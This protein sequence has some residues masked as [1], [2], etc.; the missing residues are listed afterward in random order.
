MKDSTPPCETL[1]ITRPIANREDQIALIKSRGPN[2]RGV[3][4]AYLAKTMCLN[5]IEPQSTSLCK[6]Q[7]IT[8]S[9]IGKKIHLYPTYATS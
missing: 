3:G 5:Q 2:S 9:L 8:T 6:P 4:L 1:A 7:I